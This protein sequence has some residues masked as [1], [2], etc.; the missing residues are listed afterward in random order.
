M[1]S[2]QAHMASFVLRHS[3]KPRLAG[4]RSVADMRALM[5][6]GIGFKVPADIRV[7]E[8]VL[9]GIPGEWVE[10]RIAATDKHLLYVHGGGYVACSA[11]T[12]RPLSSA[13]AQQGFRVF[14]PDYRL[15]PEHPFPAGLTDVLAV[16]RAL[17]ATT[18]NNNSRLVV[19]GDSA[20]GG[21][22]LA[23]MLALRDNN[24]PLPVAAAIFSP[25]ANLAE[26]GGSRRIN[27]G[28]CALFRPTSLSRFKD[29]YLGNSDPRL[30][31]ASPVLADLRGL[32]PLLIHVAEDEALLDDG[33]RLARRARES[34]VHVEF[35]VWPVVPHLFQLF[36]HMIPEGRQ[37]LVSAGRFLRSA[38]AGVAS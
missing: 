24:E 35:A 18:G 20:G 37:S 12:H 32:P 8:A 28:S 25:F 29:L 1:V 13:F 26:D 5:N 14:V 19:A 36:H 22:A 16:Y 38:A 15:A 21:L 34:G 4:A 11:R 6:T 27:E 23:T 2:W 7:T 33:S 10:P 31:L 3:F 9:G 17:H 30:P